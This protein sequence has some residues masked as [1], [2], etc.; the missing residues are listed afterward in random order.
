MTKSIIG[1]IGLVVA[2]ALYTGIGTS[3]N[4]PEIKEKVPQAMEDRGWEIM[5]YEGYEF[6]SWNK[7]G[8]FCW[9]HVRNV[10]NENIQYRVRVAMWDDELQ[11]YYGA[12]EKLN[13]LDVKLGE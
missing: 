1:T 10:D 8:G 2:L 9:Y 11:F 7:H 6:G 5:R 13:R 3:G 4:I 12:P